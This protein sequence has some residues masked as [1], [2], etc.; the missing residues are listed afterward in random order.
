MGTFTLRKRGQDTRFSNFILMLKSAEVK[1]AMH[2]T[3]KMPTIAAML[4]SAKVIQGRYPGLKSSKTGE[5]WDQIHNPW[6]FIHLTK[7][8]SN[9]KIIST[10]DENLRV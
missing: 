3:V 8:V 7:V 10:N 4:V 1:S 5:V 9:L 2:I 6:W